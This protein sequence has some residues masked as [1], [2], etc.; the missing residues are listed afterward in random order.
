MVKLVVVIGITG[1][2]GGSVASTILQ[3]PAWRIRGLTRDTHS[4]ESKALSA[5]GVEMVQANLHDPSSL[6]DVFKGANLVFS[7]TDFWKPLF[8]PENQARAKEQ[9]KSVGQYAYELELE[10]GENIV[11]A[12][13]REVDGLDDVG[14]LASTLCSAKKLSN[15]KYQE[16]YHFDSKADVFPTYLQDKYPALARKTSYLQTGYF[17]TSWRFMPGLWFAKQPDGSI[18]MQ[19]PTHPDT[20]IPHLDPRKD[21]GPHVRALLQLPPSSTLMAASEW[22][23]WPQWI[24]LFGDIKGVKTSYKQI[25]VNDMDA[26][27]PGGVGR[28]IGEMYEFSSEMGYNASQAD[29]LM[30]W[31]L[32]KMGIKVE[33]TSLRE[34]VEA[35]DW[36]AAGILPV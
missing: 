18:Q 33:T 8:D 25:S 1:N 30:R 2:Q 35:E 34:Y 29:T 20:L 4:A 9:R 14:F 13:A 5:Q 22:L 32:E 12:V 16:L 26:Y 23:T 36:V 11:D 24:E 10:Q 15:G 28:E 6:R 21:T 27:A 7:V 19:F 17:F 3:D 31:D